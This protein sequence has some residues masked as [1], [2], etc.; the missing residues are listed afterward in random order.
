M[1]VVAGVMVVVAVAV[2][3]EE[4]QRNRVGRGLMDRLRLLEVGGV[5]RFYQAVPGR[6]QTSLPRRP[7]RH[8]A[9]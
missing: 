7:V 1:A 8:H 3:D 4:Y 9:S 2:A 5:P 6:L